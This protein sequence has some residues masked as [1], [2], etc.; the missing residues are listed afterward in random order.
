MWNGKKTE[1]LLLRMSEEMAR[2]V[3]ALAEL[4]HRSL[5]DEIRFLIARGLDHSMPETLKDK[6]GPKRQLSS[7]GVNSRQ[8]QGEE[9]A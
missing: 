5:Q 2:T 3:R 9:V 6:P 7:T 8:P 1:R 4:H